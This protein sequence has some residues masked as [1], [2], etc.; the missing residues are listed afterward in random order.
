MH[1]RK[2]RADRE[3]EDIRAHQKTEGTD[4]HQQGFRS[5]LAQQH[6]ERAS[7][8]YNQAQR[9]VEITAMELGA[10]EYHAK[11]MGI[12]ALRAKRM[13]DCYA[14]EL[15]MFRYHA[16]CQAAEANVA[17]QFAHG[18]LQAAS[19]A[20]MIAERYTEGVQTSSVGAAPVL[21]NRV[22]TAVESLD[23]WR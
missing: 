22:P 15:A 17:R 19:T 20:S 3:A 4:D 18:Q 1:I 11:Q 6:A 23:R 5:L 14:Q 12:Q 10:A 7:L 13:A 9:F 8:E 21:V 16:I 2:Q